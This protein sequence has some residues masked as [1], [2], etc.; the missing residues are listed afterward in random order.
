MR[1]K[2]YSEALRFARCAGEDAANRR[3]R[4]AGRKVMSLDDYNHAVDVMEKM[5]FDLGFDTRGWM[6]MAGVPRNEPPE[7]PKPKATRRSKRPSKAEPDQFSFG[8]A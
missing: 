5:L 2:N 6:A 3:M 7:L 1:V 8:F 4:K